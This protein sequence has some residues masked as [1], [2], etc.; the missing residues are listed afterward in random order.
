[1]KV[2]EQDSRA[3]LKRIR[4]ARE[5]YERDVAHRDESSKFWKGLVNR[6]DRALEIART[7]P[8][9]PSQTQQP[10]LAL[11]D[12]TTLLSVQAPDTSLPTVIPA[13]R[14]G[15][16]GDRVSAW[17][18]FLR[19]REIDPGPIDGIFGR[20]T[21]TATTAFQRKYRLAEDGVAGR[22]TLLKAAALGFEL[23]EEPA[24]DKTGS[25]FPPHPPFQPLVTTAQREALFGHFDYIPAP[26]SNNR[27]RIRI[28]GTWQE[29][30]IIDVPIP[31]LR[32]V[33]GS[34]A[35]ATIQFHRLA[36]K[37]LQGLWKAW[38]SAKLL[39]RILSY[40]GSFSPRFVRGS[41]QTLSNHAFGTAF[42]INEP[43]NKLGT[44]PALVGAKGSVRELVPIANDWGFFWGG[45]YDHRPDGMHF[46]VAVLQ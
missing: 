16:R 26:T 42:D 40:Q 4:D 23:I 1:M 37:Q 24:D 9:S 35:P 18:S 12:K 39:N 46:E 44:R 13:L 45:Q 30:N 17:Q 33:L 31:Q 20:R 11:S 43:Y 6:W 14:I 15:M 8:M 32:K 5:Q 19:G 36:A 3:L 27:E 38:E 29:D 28:V 41:T 7:F 21:R 34:K 22:Q 10:I 2:A 25:D